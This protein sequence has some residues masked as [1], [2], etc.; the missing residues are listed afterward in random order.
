MDNQPKVFL[1]KFAEDGHG[2]NLIIRCTRGKTSLFVATVDVVDDGNVR[3]KFDD[4]K[5][6]QQSWSEAADHTGL[7]A[8]DPI[9]LARRLAQTE[10]FLFEYKPFQ[11]QP[12]TVEFKVKGLTEK[13]GPVEEA[14]GWAKID[15]A[16]ATAAAAAKRDTERERQRDAMLREALSKLVH[17]CREEYLKTQGEWW[18]WYDP[19]DS[20][21]KNGGPPTRTK[22]EA[23]DDAVERAKSGRIFVREM[24][25]INRKL[26]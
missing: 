24:E 1:N 19:D 25:Q 2:V 20:F 23:I 10:T 14:C 21:Y 12:T 4:A 5:P 9:G 16:K 8:P 17:P 7:F 26:K 15:Q 11:K 22:E 13:L 6:Q 18:C 3:V